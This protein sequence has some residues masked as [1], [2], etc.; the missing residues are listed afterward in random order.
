MF[1]SGRRTAQ[2]CSSGIQ[3]QPV[4]VQK[5]SKRPI[6]KN[7]DSDKRNGVLRL[8]VPAMNWILKQIANPF[9]DYRAQKF[10]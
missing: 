3:T 4:L 5:I 1:L 6:Q 10:F 8:R 2:G 7:D 9:S